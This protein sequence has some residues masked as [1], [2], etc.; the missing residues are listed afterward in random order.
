MTE[1]GSHFLC[2]ATFLAL[3]QSLHLLF[4]YLSFDFE[5]PEAPLFRLCVSVH[6]NDDSLPVIRLFLIGDRGAVNLALGKAAL[7]GLDHASH[8]IQLVEVSLGFGF[9]PVGQPLQIIGAGQ[10]I[11]CIRHSRL[12]GD[13][14]LSPKGD[15]HRFLCGQ[16]QRFVQGIRVQ[17][18]GSSQNCGERLKRYPDDVVVRLLRG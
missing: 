13:D 12:L 14:L 6:A 9:H 8:L 1:H 3:L 5:N 15:L 16:G 7:D 18:L 10:W 11:D 2:V 17:R 4:F